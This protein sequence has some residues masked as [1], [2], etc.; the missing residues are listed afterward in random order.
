VSGRA[1][2]SGS[3]LST[4]DQKGRVAIPPALRNAIIANNSGSS[5][6]E[7]DSRRFWLGRHDSAKALIGYDQARLDVLNA[8]IEAGEQAAAANGGNFTDHKT[9]QRLFPSVEPVPFDGSG[10]FILS[11]KF[12]ARGE[13]EDLAY[14]YGLGNV[15]TIWNPQLL[16]ADANVTEEIKEDCLWALKEKGLA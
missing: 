12:K 9:R 16:M 5:A 11:P 7:D 14:F 13:L 8:N 10:R 15:F 4:I 1:L 2:I 3:G 6:S